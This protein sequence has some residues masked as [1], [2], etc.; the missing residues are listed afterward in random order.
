MRVWHPQGSARGG[1]LRWWIL[2]VQKAGGVQQEYA[3]RCRI[4]RTK[5]MPARAYM[6]LRVCAVLCFCCERMRVAAGLGLRMCCCA[7]LV[8]LLH[9]LVWKQKSMGLHF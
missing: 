7:C 8:D 2:E 6:C 3:V 5:G 9:G 1:L 4:E